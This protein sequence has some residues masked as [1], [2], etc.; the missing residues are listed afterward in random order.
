MKAISYILLI[1]FFSVTFTPG[2]IILL[3]K[4]KEQCEMK[5]SMSGGKETCDMSDLDCCPATCN[6]TQCCFCCFNCTVDTKK[7]EIKIFE[8]NSSN[9]NL[10]GH[11][12]LSDFSSYC[13]Q[14]PK[15]G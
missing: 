14:P 9:Q 10:D 13:W 7:L 3:R 4:L 15:K 6:P 12:D 11:Y 5:C 1:S 2:S 8:P